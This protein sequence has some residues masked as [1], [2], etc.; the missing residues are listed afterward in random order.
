MK[1]ILFAS[2]GHMADG[3]LSAVKL[4]LGDNVSVDTI[5]A[6]LDDVSPSGQIK[7]YF[8]ALEESDQAIILTDL[9]GGSVNKEILPYVQK[10]NVYVITGMNLAMALEIAAMS[11][12]E[13]ITEE[14]CRNL[15][16]MGKSQ[17]IYVNDCVKEKSAEE[18]EFE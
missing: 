13:A 14:F 7:E 17:V 8:D 18:E 1:K 2:H 15:A 10:P 16:E 3:V 4:I 5:N 12:E 9:L 11:E 6:Y